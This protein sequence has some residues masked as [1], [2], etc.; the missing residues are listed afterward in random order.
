MSSFNRRFIPK[1][2]FW[3]SIEGTDAT[4][5]T[6][7][8]KEIEIFFKK[9]KITNFAIIK[10]FSDSPFGAL[11]QDITHKK[12]FFSLGDKFHYPF[13]E[14][15]LLCGDFIYQFE[16]IL[17]K[18]KNRKK[19]FIISDRGLYS[20]LT[21]Q[22]LRIKNQYRSSVSHF[23][24]KWIE[25]IFKPIGFPH[26]VILLISPIKEIK[27]RIVERDGFVRKKEIQ[28]I[29]EVQNE[30]LKILKKFHL[31]HLTIKNQDGE[32][33]QVKQITIQKLK[34]ILKKEAF[35]KR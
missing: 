20:F 8:L 31:P 27:R 3:L 32:F 9:Q 26:L 17:M 33:E 30:Y 13:A 15:L 14:T 10:E 23:L 28:F 7:L 29:Q 6:S 25:E 35:S 5:K 22:L 12:K 21:Y 19:L 1:N 18:S 16:K 2:Y 24:E 34:E 11:I 4:G